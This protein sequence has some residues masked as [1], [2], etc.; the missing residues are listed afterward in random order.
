MNR[1][2]FRSLSFEVAAIIVSVFSLPPSAFAQSTAFT[3]QGR[4]NDGGAPANAIYDLRF[5]IYDAV[6]NG[7]S[8]GNS[9][10]NAAVP[11]TNGLFV[12]TLD[13]GNVFTGRLLWLEIGVRSGGATN[14][15]TE[16]TPRQPLTPVP[17]A[18]FADSASNLP[19]GLAATQ[20]VGTLPASAFAG[21]TNTVALTNGAN[22][23]TGTFSGNGAG[24]TNVNVTHLTGVLANN[25]LPADTA[26]VDSNQTFSGANNFTNRGNSFI[27]SFFG[28]GLVGWIATNGTAVQAQIDRGYLLTSPQLATVTLPASPSVGDIVRIAGAGASGWQLAQNANQ[29]VLGHFSSFA[30]SLWDLSGASTTLNWNAIA[31]SADGTRL[32]SVASGSGG[33]IFTS[34]DSGLNWSG[35]NGP[36][37]SASWRAIASSTDGGKLVAAIYGGGIYTNAGASWALCGAPTGLNWTSLASSG[38]GSRLAAVSNGSGG[39]D[40]I[41]VSANSGVT[42]THVLGSGNWAAVASST[43]GSRL[44]A[45]GGAGVWISANSGSS[46]AEPLS[47][48]NWTAVASSVDG[49]KLVAAGGGGIWVSANSGS[50][51]SQVLGSA[52][53]TAVAAS[54]DGSK[55]AAAVSGSGIYVSSNYG[56]TWSQQTGAPV[57]N[58]SAL[59]SSSDGSRLAAAVNS[60]TS[61]GIYTAQASALNVTTA[62]TTGYLTGGQGTAVELQYIGNN[63]FMPVNSAGAIWAR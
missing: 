12:T 44:I 10:T 46:W 24:L 19:G 34:T 63:Q 14:N 57:K 1:K 54:S 18:I 20:L 25:Q 17:Y 23:F 47:G 21:Y 13:F 53:W 55:L 31:S 7:N 39:N 38:D 9:L 49:T 33:G 62:G 52:N 51:W 26:F 42:W 27:G 45:A 35:P 41:Y 56:V 48:A 43:D 2:I 58:W 8:V 22:L 36:L 28:N 11:V 5:A 61:G 60:A 59:A 30:N 16:L 50:T 40:G 29:S 15:F 3:Y 4:L 32:A 37:V 6:T